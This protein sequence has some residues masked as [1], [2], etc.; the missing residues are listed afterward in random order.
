M[1]NAE[2]QVSVLCRCC[3]QCR[4]LCMGIGMGIYMCADM[5]CVLHA[6][7]C[8]LRAACCVP[9]CCVLCAVCGVLC[10]VCGVLCAVCGVLRA[11]SICF[12][13]TLS[14]SIAMAV[15]VC[16]ARQHTPRLHRVY[17]RHRC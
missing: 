12:L 5:C 13:C 4:V 2:L 17:P 6:V 1:D 10:A 8:V 14:L 7:C 16:Q 15:S 3:R 11:V 9:L